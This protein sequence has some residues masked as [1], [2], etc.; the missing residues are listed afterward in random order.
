MGFDYKSAQLTNAD[1]VPKVL[2]NP[3][4]SGRV[5]CEYFSYTIPAGDLAVGKTLEL[6]RLRKGMRPILGHLSCTA[7]STAG[8]TAGVLVGD[9]TTAN[10]YMAETSVD[11][12]SNIIFLS[13]PA[14]NRGVELTQDTSIVATVGTEA[15]AAAGT[16]SGF[17][18][19]LGGH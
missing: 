17:V 13:K 7:L 6:V 10:K 1:A 4:T 19:Y 12:A 8:G 11:A 2:N 9:G 3:N 18:M 5:Y 16:I 15:W 14:E